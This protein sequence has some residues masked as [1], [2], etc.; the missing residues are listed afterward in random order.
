MQARAD[1]DEAMVSSL[2]AGMKPWASRELKNIEN[3]ENGKLLDKLTK[4]CQYPALLNDLTFG[5]FARILDMKCHEVSFLGLS[6]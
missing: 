4:L 3:Y 5:C 6:H 2:K 1:H